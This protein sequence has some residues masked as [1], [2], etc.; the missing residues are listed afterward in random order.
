MPILGR[1][2]FSIRHRI[3]QANGKIT[4]TG[5]LSHRDGH[6]EEAELELPTD[7]TGSKNDVQAIGSSVQYG[8]R[9]TTKALLNIRSRAQS[10]RRI[11]DDG[12]A[13]GGH[14]AIDAAQLEQ[15]QMLI[16]ETA[17][18]IG[19]FCQFLGVAK[20]ADIPAAKFKTAI[21]KLHEKKAKEAAR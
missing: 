16:V 1:H 6:S 21:G 8:Q 10:D 2:G 20:L 5:I 13:A 9:Y 4:V 15:I 11:D 18:D 3:S 19:R 17:S 7:K 14:G 12:A